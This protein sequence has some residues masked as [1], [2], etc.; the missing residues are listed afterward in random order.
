MSVTLN[1]DCGSDARDKIE[2]CQ[3]APFID[4]EVCVFERSELSN[5]S[6]LP[7]C[8]TCD[9]SFKDQSLGQ[10]KKSL[11]ATNVSGESEILDNF[12]KFEV[13]P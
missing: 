10:S 3:D 7:L 12:T 6:S 11:K 8:K 9:R 13:S 4:L 1:V 2:I 5:N